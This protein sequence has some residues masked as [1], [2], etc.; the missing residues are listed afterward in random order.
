[1]TGWAI[2]ELAG[3]GNKLA[4][5]VRGTIKKMVDDEK[6]TEKTIED[7]GGNVEDRQ[8]VLRACQ[9]A[10][11]RYLSEQSDLTRHHDGHVSLPNQS[12]ETTAVYDVTQ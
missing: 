6:V 10:F 3:N 1:M 12:L 4:W 7:L 9:R 11:S 5:I 2:K 8:A